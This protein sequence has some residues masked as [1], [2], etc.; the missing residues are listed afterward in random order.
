MVESNVSA[1]DTD[2]ANDNDQHSQI[3]IEEYGEAE[4]TML[5]NYLLETC[6]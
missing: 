5:N 6:T 4:L 3:N 1:S 2:L